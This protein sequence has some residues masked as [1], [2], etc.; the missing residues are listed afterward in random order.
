MRRVH[1]IS[2]PGDLGAMR[3]HGGGGAI[4]LVRKR[5]GTFNRCTRE[6]VTSH[7]KDKMDF[8]ENLGVRVRT[9]GL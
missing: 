5:D 2:R 7:C 8:C 3:E 9:L 6:I 1:N 4:F